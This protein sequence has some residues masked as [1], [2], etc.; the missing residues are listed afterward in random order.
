MII[1][2]FV[3]EEIGDILN[4]HRTLIDANKDL[5]DHST[6]VSLLSI[7]KE[8]LCILFSCFLMILNDDYMYVIHLKIIFV[9]IYYNYY[10]T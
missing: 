9:C 4:R 1:A 10:C 3:V 8:K 5:L 2:H 7:L 6:D